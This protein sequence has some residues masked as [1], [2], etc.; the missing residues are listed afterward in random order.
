[1]ADRQEILDNK[2]NTLPDQAFHDGTHRMAEGREEL[3]LHFE[4]MLH[5]N[6]TRGKHGS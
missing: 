2:R 1:M 4:L 6:E 3:H 5:G